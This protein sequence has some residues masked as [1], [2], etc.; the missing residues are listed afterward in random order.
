MLG[1]GLPGVDIQAH[2]GLF[3]WLT[4]CAKLKVG[5]QVRL[6]AVSQITDLDISY[7]SF[8]ELEWN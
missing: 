8:R 3:P 1:M 7:L 6:P 4:L 2:A 5:Q